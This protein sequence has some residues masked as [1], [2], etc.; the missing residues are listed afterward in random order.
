MIT[1][2]YNQGEMKHLINDDL[3]KIKNLAISQ[4]KVIAFN[5]F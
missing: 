2:R 1:S 3:K 5:E 4:N